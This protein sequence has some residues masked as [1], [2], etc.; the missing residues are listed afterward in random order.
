MLTRFFEILNSN[1]EVKSLL[2]NNP[3]RV[4]P[5]GTKLGASP[6]KPYALYGLFNSTP[7]N[8]LKDRTDMDLSG[9]QV[10]I[11][12]ETSSNVIECFNSIRNAIENDAYVTSFSTSDTDIEDGL[13]HVRLEVDFHDER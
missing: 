12:S 6:K 5:Y 2:G 11:Y 7:Y 8:Y 13:F 10:D 3:L 4:Y 1:T 9:L